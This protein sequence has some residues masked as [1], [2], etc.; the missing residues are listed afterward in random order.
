MKSMC[1]RV[2]SQDSAVEGKVRAEP[3]D[4]GWVIHNVAG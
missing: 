4:K 3:V 2:R 1:V